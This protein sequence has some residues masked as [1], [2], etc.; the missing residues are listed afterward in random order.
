MYAVPGPV[1]NPSVQPGSPI[2]LTWGAPLQPNG[3]IL[4]YEVSYRAGDTQPS[5]NNVGMSTMF[6]FPDLPP[7]TRVTNIAIT[8]YTGVGAGIATSVPDVV[9][10]GNGEFL[11]Y[12]VEKLFCLI[13]NDRPLNSQ[14]FWW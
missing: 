5:T 1:S 13:V 7:G 2:V 4:K 9:S 11:T 12:P 8:A 3:I 10:Y 6:T 14:L